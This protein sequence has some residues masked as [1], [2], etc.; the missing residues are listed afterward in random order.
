MRIAFALVAALALLACGR[1]ETNAPPAG[2][3]PVS[4]PAPSAAAQPARVS[5]IDLGS[6][7]G[8]DKRV[9]APAESFAPGDTIY[10]SI[11]TEGAA[12][13]LT[14][15]AR[16]TYEDGQ[17]V[18]EASETIAPEGP[19]TTEFHIAKPDGFPAG[20]YQVEI[21]ADGAMAG[22]RRFEVR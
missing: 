21:L 20:R 11:S 9:T 4:A 10:A 18:N 1:S 5:G 3:P 8:A 7:I 12:P 19:A 16:W 17:L 2:T 15:T 6:A 14:L 13:S 22:T